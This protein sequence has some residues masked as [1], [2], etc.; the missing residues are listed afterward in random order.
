VSY[1]EILETF[2]ILSVSYEEM[3][4]EILE[5]FLILSDYYLS[6]EETSN[7][8]FVVVRNH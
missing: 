2:L 1:E 5:T 6:R 3:L 4:E 7:L 8:M